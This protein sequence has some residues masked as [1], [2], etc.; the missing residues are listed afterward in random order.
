MR[1]RD[2]RASRGRLALFVSLGA[3]SLWL[4]APLAAQ[5]ANQFTVEAQPDSYGAIVTD[6]AGNGYLAWNHEAGVSTDVPMFCK[7]APGARKC[8]HPISLT[9]PGGP[10]FASDDQPSPILGPPGVVWVV[11]SRYIANDTVIWTSTDGGQTFS[12]PYDIPYIPNCPIAGPCA[13]SFN[14]TNLTNVD[15]MLPVTPS[16][17][18]YN[19]QLYK[20]STGQPSVY[21]LEASN[22]PGLGFNLDNTNE[23]SGG[24]AG[25]SEFQFGNPGPG[26]IAGSALGLTSTGEVVEAYWRES[27][28][29][30][31]A[32]YYFRAANPAPVSPQAG[33]S[34]PTVVGSGDV[35]RL[36][37][38][39]AGLFMLSSDSLHSG[40]EPTAVDIRKYNPSTHTF[41]AP[42]TLISHPADTADL[43][44]GGGLGENYDTGEL[45]AVWPQF[46]GSATS[47]MRLYLSTD[48]GTRFSPA[49]YIATVGGS[50]RDMDNARVAIADSGTG[51]V[52]FRDAGGIEVADLAPIAAQYKTLKS[53]GK[54]VDV[55]VT[56]PAPKGT[57]KVELKLTRGKGKTLATGKFVIAA[58]ATKTLK[59]PLEAAGIK[60][61]ASGH[62]HFT[63]TLT[64]VLHSSAGAQTTTAHVTVRR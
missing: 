64:V 9:L 30:T 45:A 15:D 54:V 59:V 3:L 47:L 22:N 19:G 6:A 12:A 8:A 62:G 24:S 50:Y 46:S 41:G 36:A 61:L 37:D 38:G 42:L 1:A 49:Q 18:A 13:L 11:A 43:F 27:S 60:L 53:N 17:A 57:C 29:P 5:A 35:P 34:G 25:A 23:T 39:A 56:C 10:E 44:T 52:T 20:T 58:G 51:F 14:F 2:W 48:G 31:L 63:A 16:Y 28:P 32:Y 4:A 55:P 7:L 33:W 40:A 26:G 21:W